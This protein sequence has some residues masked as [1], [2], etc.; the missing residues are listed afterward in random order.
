MSETKAEAVGTEPVGIL[1]SRD[2]IFTSK[3][4]GTARELGYRVQVVGTLNLASTVIEESRPRVVFVDLSAG[5]LVSLP[6][7]IAYRKLA[8]TETTFLAFGSHV[9]TQALAGA[10]SAGCDPVMPRSKFSAELPDLI[11]RYFAEP[12]R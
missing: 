6:A 10:K 1:L 12:A 8:P 9:D 11:R 7:I 2:L 4:T 5:D 3:I